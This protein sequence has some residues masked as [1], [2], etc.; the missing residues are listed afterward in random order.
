MLPGDCIA[1]NLDWSNAPK[2]TVVS[3]FHSEF[4]KFMNDNY[5]SDSSLKNQHHIVFY[6]W[7]ADFIAL[8][9]PTPLGQFFRLFMCLACYLQMNNIL[10]G[11]HRESCQWRDTFPCQ[12]VSAVVTERKQTVWFL[13]LFSDLISSSVKHISQSCNFLI[14]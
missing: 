7:Q 12:C 8:F 13:L 14:K 10:H 9:H 6:M 11:K 4:L 5:V 2:E 3:H 1:K